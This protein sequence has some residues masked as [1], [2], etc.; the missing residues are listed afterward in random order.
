MKK[1]CFALLTPLILIVPLA[2][3]QKIKSD[4]NPDYD[5]SALKTFAF[6]PLNPSDPLST[7]LTCS[8][9]SAHNRV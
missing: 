1:A 4:L 9:R 8:P 2:S 5:A 3:A 6:A 7:H